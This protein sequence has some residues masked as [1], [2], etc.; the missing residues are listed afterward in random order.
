[1]TLPRIAFIGIGLMG[2]RM[3]GRLLDAGYPLSVRDLDPE[4][5]APLAARGA[6]AAASVADAVADADIV[7]TSLAGA[8]AIE[9]VYFGPDGIVPAAPASALLVDMSSVAPDIARDTHQRLAEAGGQ[10]QRDQHPRE[11]SILHVF[12]LHQRF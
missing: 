1:M 2:S 10:A 4:K 8:R 6:R 12:L 7:I 9:A 3:A 5:C 11:F